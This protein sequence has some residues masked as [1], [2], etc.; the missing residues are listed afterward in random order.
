MILLRRIEQ[1]LKISGE[2]PC[3]FGRRV[4]RD[5]N[6]MKDLRYGRQPG[7]RLRMRIEAYIAACATDRAGAMETPD[8]N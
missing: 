7:P 3:Q 6:L 2:R 5:P 4:A 8:S 1:H